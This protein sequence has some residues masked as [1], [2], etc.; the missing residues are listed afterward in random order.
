MI[1]LDENCKFKLELRLEAQMP[2]IHF[3]SQMAGATIRASEVKPKL[4]R[5]IL[6]KL[7]QKTKKN[8]EELKADPEF[9][10]LFLDAKSNTNDGFD[11]KMQITVANRV[12][13]IDLNNDEKNYSIFYAN[14][15]RESDK[16]IYG[17]FSN[18]I[19]TIICFKEELRK[20]LIQYLEE[21]FLVTNFGTMQNKGFGS[22]APVG[23]CNKGV[24][25]NVQEKEIA[26][27]YQSLIPGCHC[28]AIRFNGMQNR[29][30]DVLNTACQE[31]S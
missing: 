25:N 28:Y 1:Q 13:E 9:I 21:F 30:L 16:K 3:Q 10:P 31:K 24:L 11:Y 27:Y 6:E 18:P 14:M 12:Q 29:S 15:G 22:F 5:F 23:W 4:D 2:M 26:S 17:V 8:K 20:L 7:I 19:V